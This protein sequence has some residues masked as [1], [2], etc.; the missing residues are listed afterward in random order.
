MYILNTHVKKKQPCMSNQCY[1]FFIFN[2]IVTMRK[3]DSCYLLFDQYTN[4]FKKFKKNKKRR[5]KT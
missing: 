3:R 1:L 5:N 4:F 2:L